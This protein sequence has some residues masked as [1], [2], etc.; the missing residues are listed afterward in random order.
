VT[1]V[2]VY[3]SR[4]AAE[5]I[6]VERLKF[7]ARDLGIVQWRVETST[8][9]TRGRVRVTMSGDVAQLLADELRAAVTTGAT[10]QIRDECAGAFGELKREIKVANMLVVRDKSDAERGILGT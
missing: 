2:Q 6:D 8:Y 3:L 9:K 10:Q 7:R 5:A 1:V 4:I